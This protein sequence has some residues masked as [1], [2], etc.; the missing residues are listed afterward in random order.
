[1]YSIIKRSLKDRVRKDAIFKKFYKVMVVP[2]DC[3]NETK[4]LNTR[5]FSRVQLA[6]MSF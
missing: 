1:M 2:C 3:R 4:T 6:E 5:I